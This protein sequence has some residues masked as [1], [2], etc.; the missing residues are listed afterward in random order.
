[1]LKKTKFKGIDIDTSYSLDVSHSQIEQALENLYYKSSK[2]RSIIHE[3]QKNGESI[4]ILPAA[5]D[6]LAPENPSFTEY[7]ADRPKIYA[8]SADI[9]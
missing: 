4:T 9:D 2:F 1:M 6:S 7:D 8:Y 3:I 5:G